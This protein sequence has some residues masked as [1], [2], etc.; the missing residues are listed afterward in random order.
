MKK[1]F[2]KWRPW[3]DA[4]FREAFSV[5]RASWKEVNDFC[6]MTDKVLDGR[7]FTEDELDGVLHR[8]QDPATGLVASVRKMGELYDIL[9]KTSKVD[10]GSGGSL[11]AVPDDPGAHN[12][13]RLLSVRQENLLLLFSIFLLHETIYKSTVDFVY[14]CSGRNRINK[15]QTQQRADYL[16]K[17]G[18]DV[19][20]GADYF[21]RNGIAHSS[22]LV[23]DDNNIR[24]ADAT[25]GPS[26]ARYNP[27]S[28]LPPSGTK[29]YNR[30]ELIDEFERRQLFMANAARGVIYWFHVNHGMHRLFDDGFFGSGKRDA[31]REEALAEMKKHASV[32]V[33]KDILAK[34]E[35]KLP[36]R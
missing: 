21:L 14:E 28:E 20:P 30:R 9:V 5:D 23:V 17:R 19:T 31:V 18:F 3:F 36:R 35:R 16:A 22:F 15:T 6:G 33:W 13:R 10:V 12:V 2:Q 4:D 32:R 8:L 24:V 34:F 27:E 26:L 29:D 11:K 1:T 25:R 7:D